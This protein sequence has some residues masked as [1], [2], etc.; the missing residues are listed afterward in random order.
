MAGFVVF[1]FIERRYYERTPYGANHVVGLV[2]VLAILAI[3]GYHANTK[4]WRESSERGASAP[5]LA[6]YP[7][8]AH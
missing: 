7:H 8:C 4:A 1:D 6:K 3:A 5:S 2:V